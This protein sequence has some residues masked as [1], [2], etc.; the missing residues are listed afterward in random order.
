MITHGDFGI[1]RSKKKFCIRRVT[2]KVSMTCTS[3]QT[4]L[5]QELG[6]GLALNPEALHCFCK[7]TGAA[8][9]LYSYFDA[10][11]FESKHG[12]FKAK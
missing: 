1:L 12:C 4:A 10:H 9:Y 8:L 7:G 2:V 3:I 6:K 5:W 11:D